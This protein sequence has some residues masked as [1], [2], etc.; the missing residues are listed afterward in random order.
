MNKGRLNSTS[1]FIIFICIPLL[2]YSSNLIS[3]LQSNSSA[4]GGDHQVKVKGIVKDEQG[5]PLQCVLVV[6]EP[7]G[8]TP[9]TLPEIARYTSEK[10]EFIWYLPPGEYQFVLSKEGYQTLKEAITI[11]ENQSVTLT[12]TMKKK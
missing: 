7:Q 10:G 8:D 12:F 1:I 3:P 9:F 11:Q 4:S 5:M 6:P 2:V